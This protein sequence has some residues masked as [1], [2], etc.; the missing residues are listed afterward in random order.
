[1]I[2]ECKACQYGFET[3]GLTKACINCGSDNL[4]YTGF[5]KFVPITHGNMAADV[6]IMIAPL[7]KL[8]W[9]V[10]ITT[11]ESC[12]DP[13]EWCQRPSVKKI[14][15]TIYFN[16]LKEPSRFME[17]VYEPTQEEISYAEGLPI[18]LP[19]DKWKVGIIPMWK[20]GH[21]VYNVNVSF[22]MDQ[23][24]FIMERLSLYI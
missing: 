9:Q 7:V 15:S 21:I 1:M 2:Y 16:G 11:S 6:D 8:M 22:P 14:W 3:T 17:M 20:E 4:Q 5:H 24:S 13:E 12:Q 18:T 23:I 10:G 19:F